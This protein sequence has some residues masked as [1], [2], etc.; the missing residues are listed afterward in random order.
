MRRERSQHLLSGLAYCDCGFE[1]LSA[2]TADVINFLGKFLN[3]VVVYKWLPGFYFNPQEKAK[4]KGNRQD[5]DPA[6]SGQE[7]TNGYSITTEIISDNLIFE[8]I[9]LNFVFK[10]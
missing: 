9:G 1:S 6:K 2:F 8:V 7:V 10:N 5:P 4:G 3:S